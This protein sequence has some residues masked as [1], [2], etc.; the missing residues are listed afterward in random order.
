MVDAWLDPRTQELKDVRV[1]I[2]AI[3]EPVLVP[4]PVGKAV[5]NVTNDGPEL[6]EPV[7]V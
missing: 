3:P 1:M 6:I 7:E 2:D 4:R 5:G